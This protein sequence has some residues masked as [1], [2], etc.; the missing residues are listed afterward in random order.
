MTASDPSP[1]DSASD[2]RDTQREKMVARETKIL[3][4]ATKVF[5]ERGVD[6]AK[7]AEIAK[8][9]N[10]AEGTLYLYYR[11]KQ[12]LL[13]GVVGNFWRNL[14]EGAIAA[15][16]DAESIEE[17]LMALARYHLNALLDQFEVVALTYRARQRH[18]EPEFQL[19]QIR[20]YV[21]VFDQV[22]QRGVDRGY[23]AQDIN[24]WQVRDAFYGTL[25][26]SARTLHLRGD[27][28]DESV[29]ENLMRMLSC[30]R[31]WSSQTAYSEPERAGDERASAE[32]VFIRSQQDIVERLAR[33]EA[34]LAKG[35]S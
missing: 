6:G 33:I 11:N 28:Y 4:A 20:D 8:D 24:L 2:R 12:D 5:A 31:T 22:I 7:M 17:Q 14:T 27:S 21:K 30:Y 18:G 35:N 9:A 13:A 26:F 34:A 3:Q 19:A 16:A 10:V 15:M 1:K 25:E 29:V 23:F 32:Y